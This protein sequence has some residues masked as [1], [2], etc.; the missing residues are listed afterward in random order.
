MLRRTSICAVLSCCL[1]HAVRDRGRCCAI[2]VSDIYSCF[3][4]KC[5]HPFFTKIMEGKSQA[6]WEW[7]PT[8]LAAMIIWPSMWR[9]CNDFTEATVFLY[10]PTEVGEQQGVGAAFRGG[11]LNTRDAC[12]STFGVVQQFSAFRCFRV[13][14]ATLI[15]LM[16]C[17]SQKNKSRRL[18]VTHK[19]GVLRC[20][21]TAVAT[22][23]EC[24]VVQP[25]QKPLRVVF[26]AVAAVMI[27]SAA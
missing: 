25:T 26:V 4:F 23:R 21:S 14:T 27:V 2:R 1:A 11:M 7:H 15:L 22:W 20:C 17:F 10:H 9:I 19:R 5:V 3:P 18:E 24:T 8:A 12:S 13:L 6:S 16:P